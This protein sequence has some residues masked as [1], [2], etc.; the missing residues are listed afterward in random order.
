MDRGLQKG[1]ERPVFCEAECYGGSGGED[2]E[3]SEEGLGYW[4]EGWGHFW[5]EFRY[6]R[7]GVGIYGRRSDLGKDLIF[8]GLVRE[9]RGEVDEVERRSKSGRVM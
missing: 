8:W 2:W 6:S 3:E 5:V 4:W 9:K 1:D 7:L